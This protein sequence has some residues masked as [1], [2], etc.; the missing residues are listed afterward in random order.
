[1]SYGIVCIIEQ[2]KAQGYTK[3]IY[4]TLQRSTCREGWPTSDLHIAG[5]YPVCSIYRE[6]GAVIAMYV[7]VLYTCI[8]MGL[9]QLDVIGFQVLHALC[10]YLGDQ[11]LPT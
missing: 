2:G 7:C 6:R 3:G 11:C 8:P 10:A 4:K 5:L 9:C 1:M